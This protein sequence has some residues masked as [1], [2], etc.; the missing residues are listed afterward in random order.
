[1]GQSRKR[2]RR[3]K[4]ADVRSLMTSSRKRRPTAAKKTRCK[5][6]HAGPSRQEQT[7]E[8]RVLEEEQK[9][10][11]GGAEKKGVS[12]GSSGRDGN[13]VLGGSFG[14]ALIITSMV[15]GLVDEEA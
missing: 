8:A 14:T 5:K 7:R 13:K 15:R 9:R 3:K 4:K 10:G 6:P 11:L 1:V 12:G 2:G